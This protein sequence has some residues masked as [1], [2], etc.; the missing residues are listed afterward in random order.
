MSKKSKNIKARLYI[1]GLRSIFS[2]MTELL[3]EVEKTGEVPSNIEQSLSDVSE[4]I[5]MTVKRLKMVTSKCCEH[6]TENLDE[7]G[8][9]EE[10]EEEFSKKC[11][12]CE[13]HHPQMIDDSEEEPSEEEV[14]EKQSSSKKRKSSSVK[15][16]KITNNKEK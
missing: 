13:K 14:E 7:K 11:S 3:T 10:E 4:A 9:D 1:G 8:E 2:D 12:S 15:S 5:V 6:S 16:K